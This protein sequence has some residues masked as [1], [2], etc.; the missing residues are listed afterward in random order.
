MGME[1]KEGWDENG[2][3]LGLRKVW[4]VQWRWRLRWKQM[5]TDE[6]GHGYR[7]RGVRK[8]ENTD[9]NREGMEMEAELKIGKGWEVQWR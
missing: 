6:D 2:D 5:E 1:M 9:G 4:E 8:D 3:R 7:Y